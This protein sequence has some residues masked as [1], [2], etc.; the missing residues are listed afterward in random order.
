MYFIDHIIDKLSEK[1]YRL[2]QVST[3]DTSDSEED[4]I[5]KQ[6]SRL[7]ITDAY[8]ESDDESVTSSDSDE[9][10]SYTTS[11]VLDDTNCMYLSKYY[12]WFCRYI[13]N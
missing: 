2:R 11:P 13:V 7:R 12:F 6:L 10:L 1:A 9:Q 3:C 4:K 8:E 5:V